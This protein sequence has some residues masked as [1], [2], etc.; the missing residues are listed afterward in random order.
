[1]MHGY[2]TQVGPISK[3][4]P[5]RQVVVGYTAD[6]KIV[7]TLPLDYLYWTERAA[8]GLNAVTRLESA[9][10]LVKRVELWI[11]GKTTPKAK[12]ELEAKGLAVK[13][14]TGERLMPP[15]MEDKTIELEKDQT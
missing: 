4:I 6:Q 11:T 12:R 13:E 14:Q 2:H 15:S 7:V 5:V 3:I 8:L 10:R 9:D 1:M